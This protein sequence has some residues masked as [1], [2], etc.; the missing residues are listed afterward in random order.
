MFIFGLIVGGILGVSVMA[1]VS[2][3]KGEDDDN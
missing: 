2:I 1:I 3:N